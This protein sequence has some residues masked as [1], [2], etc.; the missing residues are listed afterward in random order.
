V[1]ENSNES[2]SEDKILK[3]TE[4]LDACYVEIEKNTKNESQVPEEIIEID[5]NDPSSWPSITDKIRTLLINHDPEQGKNSD[6]YFSENITDKRRFTINLFTK[7]LPNG[8][9]VERSWLLY[10]DKTK[11]LYCF[12][13]MLFEN[14]TMTSSSITDP[15]KGFNNWKKFN[16][17]IPDHENSNNHRTN[18]FKWTDFKTNLNKNNTIDC[19]LQL[20]IN[21]E[22]EK[23]KHILKV[24]IDCVRFCCVNN[25]ALRGSNCDVEKPGC[26]IFLNLI[27]LISNYDSVLSSHLKCHGQT[28]YLSNKIQ[29]E[30]INLLGSK[31]RNEIIHRIK[32]SKYFFIIFDST[33]DVSRKEQLCQIIRY[34][35]EVNNEFIIEESFV[36]F[37]NTNEKTGRGIATDVL[38]KLEKYGLD[39][40]N[41]RGQGYDNGTNMAGKYQGVQARLKEINKHAE[42]VPC[43][44][45]S[46]NLIGVHAACVSVKM[47]SFFGIVQNIFNYFSGSTSRWEIFMSCLNIKNTQ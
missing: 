26:R 1:L 31:V 8:E 24:V 32:N 16:P 23:W 21:N 13:C 28:T 4:V 12:P 20:E 35:R 41:C 38:Q 17:K 7:I 30:F 42:F 36:D 39:F 11:F 5:F 44:A 40:K 33:P 14:K 43:A 27:S 6:F 45:H 22:K 46:L 2:I 18:M 15:Q 34:I 25:L 47:I 19:E 37:I 3:K 10:S 29:N 9:K